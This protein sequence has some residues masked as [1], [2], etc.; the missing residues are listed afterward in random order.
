MTD[1]TIKKEKPL[2]DV[3]YYALPFD[4]GIEEIENK[5]D[6]I[7]DLSKVYQLKFRPRAA[8]RGAGFY[9]L[10]ANLFTL[11][12]LFSL[13]VGGI[14]YDVM[15]S[16]LFKSAIEPL[17]DAVKKHRSK[18]VGLDIS[19][20]S[21]NFSDTVIVIEKF[22]HFDF[23]SKIPEILKTIAENASFMGLKGEFPESIYVPIC[24]ELDRD[25][26]KLI[27]REYRDVDDYL[28]LDGLVDY[29]ECYG[30]FYAR[31]DAEY[32]YSVSEKRVIETHWKTGNEADEFLSRNFE[33]YESAKRKIEEI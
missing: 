5:E 15:K 32:I 29:H 20:L 14:L 18:H 1:I 26:G 19:K 6:L 7:A 9:E 25:S 11:Q 4:Y 33:K 13:V 2:L 23:T 12:N 3:Y 21:I 30:V 16:A 31:Q 28:V 10:F 17:I 24:K 8:P 22:G 27:F